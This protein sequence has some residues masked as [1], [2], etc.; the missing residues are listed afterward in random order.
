MVYYLSLLFLSSVLLYAC[1]K[2][3][4]ILL[5][6]ELKHDEVKAFQNR[7]APEIHLTK[8]DEINFLSPAETEIQGNPHG[9]LHRTKGFD[10]AAWQIKP[11]RALLKNERGAIQITWLGHASFFIQLGQEHN[12]VT[13]PVFYH[14]PFSWLFDGLKR[15]SPPVVKARDLPGVS[16]I[17]ISHN[18]YDHLNW[19]TLR[20]FPKEIPYLVPL[21]LEQSFSKRYT[22]VTG[23]DWYMSKQF[24]DLTVTFLPAQHWSKRTPW[25]TN[26]T[27]WGGWLFTFRGKT[28][29]FAGDTAYSPIFRDM[30]Q[31]YGGFDIC[32][33]PITAYK[34]LAYRRS[35]LTP[36]GAVQAALDVGCRLVIPWGYGTFTLGMN[37]SW[38]HSDV[39]I[40]PMKR[41]NL[42]FDSKL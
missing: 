7:Y 2:K 9:P 32:L 31:R 37:I 38:N 15:A 27:L 26:K 35:H 8:Y 30:Y 23:M 40:G 4:A 22:Q 5:N 36:E 11:D 33:L 29:Y 42:L 17:V 34:P 6:P 14:L 19:K 21:R 13:D 3:H 28:I 25:D 41:F 1:S 24:A 20:K 12:I 16:L 39:Y 18:H 10:P